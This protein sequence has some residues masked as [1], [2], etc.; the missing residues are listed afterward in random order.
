[1]SGPIAFRVSSAKSVT[2]TSADWRMENFTRR[3]TTTF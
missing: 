3:R 2:R 1:M